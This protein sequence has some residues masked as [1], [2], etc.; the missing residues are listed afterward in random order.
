MFA[1][2]STGPAQ[3]QNFDP[4]INGVEKFIIGGVDNE[5]SFPQV[6]L[7]GTLDQFRSVIYFYRMRRQKNVSQME[8]Y[9]LT[10]PL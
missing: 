5:C 6:L 1:I 3:N 9:Y 8:A 4:N 2:Y 10:Y 7:Q